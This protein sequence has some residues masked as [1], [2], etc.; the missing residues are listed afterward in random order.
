MNVLFFCVNKSR[1]VS[2][3]RAK[4]N[5]KSN[6]FY[7]STGESVQ[8]K[9]FK[10]GKCTQ[11]S[12][13]ANALNYKLAK[14]A[15]AMTSA[16]LFYSREF[17]MPTQ[18]QFSTKADVFLAGSSAIT[19]HKQEKIFLDYM[20]EKIDSSK[21]K[22]STIASYNRSFNILEDFQKSKKITFDEVDRSYYSKLVAWCEKKDFSRNYMACCIKHLKKF[23]KEAHLEGKHSNIAYMSFKKEQEEADNI[24]LSLDELMS[25]HALQITKEKLDL[26]YPDRIEQQWVD[27]KI[28]NA[29]DRTRK[30]FLIGAV[31]AMRISDY[32]RIQKANIKNGTVTIMPVKGSSLRKP[33]PVIMP[34]HRIMREILESG[35][36]L[37]SYIV[38]QNFNEQI[39]VVCRMAEINEPVTL[40]MTKGGKLQSF[41]HPKWELV[42]SHTARRSGATN[43]HLSGMP[44]YLIMACTGHTTTK[45][46]YTYVKARRIANIEALRESAYFE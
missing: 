8:P 40:Y 30:K 34:M 20:R 36:D 21:M 7:Y 9:F 16:L 5:Y 27:D 12:D 10:N 32:N 38:P 45:Q 43:M 4:I 2:V 44:D 28:V 37:S 17:V 1:A 41:T 13:Q 35:F 39:K 11:K 15:N 22:D 46:L 3:I 29:L 26:C 6:V 25:I 33:E 14:I 18:E 24:Y 31:C 19:I 23:M 42:S